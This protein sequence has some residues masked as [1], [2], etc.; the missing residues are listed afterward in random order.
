MGRT[1]SPSTLVSGTGS[2]PTNGVNGSRV[3]VLALLY[4]AIM[5]L[6]YCTFGD[7]A[8]S[9]LLRN[10]AQGDS[11][12]L[13]GRLATF[14]SILFGYPLAMVGLRDAANL[15][16]YEIDDD[17]SKHDLQLT[18]YGLE[19]RP[20]RGDQRVGAA[21]EGGPGPG[22]VER[23]CACMRSGAVNVNDAAPACGGVKLQLKCKNRSNRKRRLQN[24]EQQVIANLVPQ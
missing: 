12:A 20:A 22:R 24:E 8:A 17:E 1:G 6:G 14:V 3:S 10:Y 18:E 4:T 15:I 2:G 11:L 5:L 13:L 23:R 19:V 7:H 9:N 16:Y 21:G